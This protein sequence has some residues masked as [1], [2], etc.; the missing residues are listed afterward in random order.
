MITIM[1]VWCNIINMLCYKSCK[2]IEFRFLR[3]TYNFNKIVL[4]MY[5]FNAI[6]QY[7][8]YLTQNIKSNDDRII[9]RKIQL[10][11]NGLDAIIKHVYP[12]DIALNIL[13][14]INRLRFAV[15]NQESNNDFIGALTN[16]EDDLITKTF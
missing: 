2:T 6:M 4:W 3:P 12:E 9:I 14:Y 8:E 16:F 1:Y 15:I 5:I 13:D 10:N 11:Y 7:A